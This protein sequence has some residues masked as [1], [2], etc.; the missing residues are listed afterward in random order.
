MFHQVYNAVYFCML[1]VVYCTHADSTFICFILAQ[2]YYVC[3]I[4]TR[5]ISGRKSVLSSPITW[6]DI[7]MQSL[8][9]ECYFEH[10]IF[11]FSLAALMA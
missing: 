4:Q 8:C 7:I 2:L 3:R 9:S 5:R 1:N 10:F 6:H 11:H